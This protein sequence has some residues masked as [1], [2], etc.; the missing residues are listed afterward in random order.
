MK[1]AVGSH[2]FGLEALESS[3]VANEKKHE[4]I[5]TKIESRLDTSGKNGKE[6]MKELEEIL[7]D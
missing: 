6:Q 2:A 4:G 1:A 7:S 5:V 3:I